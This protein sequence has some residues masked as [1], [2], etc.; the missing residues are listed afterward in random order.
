MINERLTMT[1]YGISLKEVTKMLLHPLSSIEVILMMFK[2]RIWCFETCWKFDK[3]SS[4]WVWLWARK[5]P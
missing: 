5:L 3:S 4:F 1:Y 2:E